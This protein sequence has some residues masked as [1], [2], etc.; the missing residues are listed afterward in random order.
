MISVTKLRNG[1]CYQDNGSPYRVVEYRHTHMS[2]GGGTIKVKV[3]NLEDGRVLSKTYKSGERVDEIDVTKEKLQFLY[4]EDGGY[5]F[6]NPESFEQVRVEAKVVGDEG[7]FLKAGEVYQVIEWDTKI[8]GMDLPPKVELEI[9][10]AAPGEKGDS[11]SNI[12]KDAVAE[13]G[14]KVRVPL[15]VN[16]GTRIRVD[17]KTREY[18]DRV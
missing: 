10:E 16:A 13:G 4:Q 7:V 11:A 17:T 2:R 9:I 8:L 5:I 15:F 14:I 18:V 3:R 12:Y 1:V 6:M